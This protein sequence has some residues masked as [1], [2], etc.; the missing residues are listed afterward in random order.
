MP[1]YNHDDQEAS[2]FPASVT[3]FADA[4]RTAAGVGM[5]SPVAP[6]GTEDGRAKNRRVEVWLRN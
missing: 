2:G 5:L 6:N 1:H 4:I 3:A